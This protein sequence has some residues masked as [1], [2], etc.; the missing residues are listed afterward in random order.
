MVRVDLC[1]TFHMPK[2]RAGN[3][4]IEGCDEDE[5]LVPNASPFTL[6]A[7]LVRTG[8]GRAVVDDEA[9][10]GAGAP[11]EGAG[12]RLGSMDKDCM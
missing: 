4:G 3:C 2:F 11:A 10:C 6:V 8:N 5:G 12:P 9:E 7:L 1:V